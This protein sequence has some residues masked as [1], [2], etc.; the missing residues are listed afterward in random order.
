MFQTAF[1]IPQDKTDILFKLLVIHGSALFRFGL[2]L[3]IRLGMGKFMEKNKNFFLFDYTGISEN[4]QDDTARQA[5]TTNMLMTE[6]KL[7]V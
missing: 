7:E 4:R 3:T 6:K 5:V 2:V 1:V